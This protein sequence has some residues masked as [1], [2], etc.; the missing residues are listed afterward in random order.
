MLGRRCSWRMWLVGGGSRR[1]KRV[2]VRGRAAARCCACVLRVRCSAVM[3]CGARRAPRKLA[4]C[5]GWCT[6][7]GRRA[8]RSAVTTAVLRKVAVARMLAA[9]A[10]AAPARISHNNLPACITI[11]GKTTGCASCAAHASVF[12]LAFW[13]GAW[14]GASFRPT[15]LNPINSGR[16]SGPELADSDL[17][18]AKLKSFSYPQLQLSLT[19]VSSRYM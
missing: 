6:P 12:G 1:R 15:A 3:S 7:R 5:R 19:L 2:C 9:A 17:L 18:L 10:A 11:P 14:G 13:G 4:R 16:D 8:G